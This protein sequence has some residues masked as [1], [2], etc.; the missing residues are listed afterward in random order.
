VSRETLSH[1]LREL[2]AR[3]RLAV[4]STSGEGQP[5]SSLVA[6]APTPDL[7]HLLFATLR[8]TRKFANLMENPRVALLVDDRSNRE[9]DLREALAVTATGQA[10]EMTGLSE[11]RALLAE[12]LTRHPSLEV[13]ASDPNCALVSVRVEAYF[14]VSRFQHVEVWKVDE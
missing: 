11:R 12:Y 13:F 14:V 5:Y 10:R 3:Q 1:I 2:F 8:S 7:R 9:T 6:F 4:L